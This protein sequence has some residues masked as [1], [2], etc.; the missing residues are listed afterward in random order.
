MYRGL[1]DSAVAAVR[2]ICPDDV[3]QGKSEEDSSVIS[4]NL[5]M[6]ASTMII[7]PRR[8]D[9]AMLTIGRKGS[10]KK[11]QVGPIAL[12]GTILAGSLMVKAQDE[13]DTL[14]HDETKLLELLGAIGIPG[15]SSSTSDI[16]VGPL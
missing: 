9:S 13:W 14:L 3:E 1:Y 5:A 4:Y 11:D 10:D 8:S 2:D 12:N 15:R 6:T 16:I 7:C